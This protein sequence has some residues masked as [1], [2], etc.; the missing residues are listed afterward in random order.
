MNL[1]EIVFIDKILHALTYGFLAVAFLYA[2][3]INGFKAPYQASFIAS[4]LYGL[5]DEIHQLFIPSRYF[6]LMDWG[7]DM[8][9]SA[10]CLTCV[11]LLKNYLRK[12]VENNQSFDKTF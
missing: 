1:P 11:A 3:L 5:S 8:V 12:P 7:A 9:G 2:M 10:L 4:S 6:D